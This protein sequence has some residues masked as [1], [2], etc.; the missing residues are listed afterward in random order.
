MDKRKYKLHT[1]LIILT[2]VI[3]MLGVASVVFYVDP[4]QIYHEQKTDGEPTLYWSNQRYTNAGIT[5][6]EIYQKG[7]F[8]TIWTGTSVTE[9]L[10]A[11]EVAEYT[12]FGPALQLTVVHGFPME[13]F[14]TLQYAL[15]SGSVQCVIWEM[16][17][18]YLAMK[19]QKQWWNPNYEFPSYL[20]TES[21][22]RKLKYLINSTA[23][24]QSLQMLQHNLKW[25]DN[26]SSYYMDTA[27]EKHSFTRFLDIAREKKIDNFSLT[28][29]DI[30]ASHIEIPTMELIT[31]LVSSYPKTQFYLYIPPLPAYRYAQNKEEAAY[32]VVFSRQLAALAAQHPNTTLFGFDDVPEINEN[33]ANYRDTIHY[34]IG[35]D[36]FILKSMHDKKHRIT[37][38][39]VDAY[40]RHFLD[41][42]TTYQPTIDM[43][44][45]ISFEGPVDEERF[46][47]Y[48]PPHGPAPIAP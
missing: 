17:P 38:G 3:Y 16:N 18:P 13:Q 40:D 24:K 47:A 25:K 48:P 44:H 29:A 2:P 28:M 8:K 41:V 12:G 42:V 15:E 32:F 21:K 23:F 37:P 27:C 1:L 10:Y 22:F 30:D 46:Q 6:T 34:G 39:N 31:K 9:D 19:K 33:L 35:V 26:N 43:E 20:Y 14:T 5:R 4:W 7:F 11:P 36:R 45:T